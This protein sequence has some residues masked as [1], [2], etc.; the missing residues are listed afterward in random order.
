M[1]MHGPSSTPIFT[2]HDGE[3]ATEFY[4]RLGFEII[5]YD[6]SYWIVVTEG[7]ELLHLQAAPAGAAHI[8]RSTAYLNVA[9]VD[10]HHHE[11]SSLGI[12]VSDLGDRPWGMREFRVE[13]PSGNTLRVGQNL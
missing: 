1:S 7:E 9:D 3:M 11:W 5:D 12:Q 4:R 2:V 6:D 8:G 13:D 10:G